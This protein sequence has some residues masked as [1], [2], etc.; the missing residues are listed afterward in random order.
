[1]FI[2]LGEI[3]TQLLI[4]LIYPIGIIAARITTYTY[5]S[6][7]YYYLFI[8]FISHYLVF[9]IKLIYSIKEKIFQ[10]KNAA[11]E[12]LFG[13]KNSKTI[14]TSSD[15]D[16]A[17]ELESTSNRIKKV[18]KKEKIVRIILI[19]ILYFISYIFFYYANFITSTNFYGNISMITEIL[20]FS[21]FNRIILGNKI[22]SHHLFAMII[23]TIGILGLYILLLVRYIDQNNYRI[24]QDILFPTILN[25]IVYLIFCV[26]LVL[27]KYYMEK[28]FIS[29]YE[30][31]IYIGSLGLLLLVLFEPLTFLIKCENPAMCFEGKFAGIIS[32]FKEYSVKDNG[33]VTIS[34]P[35]SLFMTGFGLWLTVEY[36]SPIHFLTSDSLITFGLNI[37]ID[38]YN[39]EFVLLINPLFY[40]FSIISIFGCL[41]Y[42]EII[43]LNVYG[44][45]YNTKKEINKRQF[46]EKNEIL[47]MSEKIITDNFEQDQQSEEGIN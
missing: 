29:P 42:N 34:L 23:I 44:F 16:S 26:D 18:A 12:E 11:F 1:M 33:L 32:G 37:M 13:H 39:T 22:Y 14:D 31:M 43:I 19:G 17:L 47:E 3:K 46:F 4:L 45:D 41:I 10:S 35:F 2:Q 36:L 24:W 20:Y 9:F 30:L 6:N 40:I 27:G 7:P 25:F 5:N 28:Y 8:F 21:L 38:C 15:F